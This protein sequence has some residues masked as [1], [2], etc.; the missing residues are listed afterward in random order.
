MQD[1]KVVNMNELEINV[2]MCIFK[3]HKIEQKRQ[4]AQYIIYSM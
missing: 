4:L 1:I 3:K 2:N